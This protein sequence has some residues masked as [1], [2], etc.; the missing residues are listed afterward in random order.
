MSVHREQSERARTRAKLN[1]TQSEIKGNSR[2]HFFV[3]HFKVGAH[4][5]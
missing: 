2:L 5:G 3:S 1:G 4:F